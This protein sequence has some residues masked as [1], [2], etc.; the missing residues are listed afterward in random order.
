MAYTVARRT[1]EIG[2]RMALGAFHGDVIWL[3]MREVLV[4]VCVGM[5]AGLAG[6]LHSREAGADPTLRCYGPR[7]VD[8]RPGGGRSGCGGLRGRLYSGVARQPH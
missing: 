3:V 2:I 6:S 5:A 4:L 7:S 1:R 8:C